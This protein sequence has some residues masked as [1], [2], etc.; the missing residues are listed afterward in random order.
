MVRWLLLLLAR[1]RGL[2]PVLAPVGD[3]D[4][5]RVRAVEAWLRNGALPAHWTVARPGDVV[6]RE[7]L[8]AGASK[9]CSRGRLAAGGAKVV[10]KTAA[11][12]NA[13]AAGRGSRA[14][15]VA[16]LSLARCRA[17][18]PRMHA[19]R[20]GISWRASAGGRGSRGSGAAGATRCRSSSTTAAPS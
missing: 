12:D 11:A 3:D 7:A 14:H 20:T 18:R 15:V 17:R 9:R 13:T 6:R 8:A 1:A 19:D 4:M 16:E 10:V 5:V 2:A